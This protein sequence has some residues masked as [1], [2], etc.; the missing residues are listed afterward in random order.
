MLTLGHLGLCGLCRCRRRQPRWWTSCVCG[1]CLCLLA[2]PCP[3]FFCPAPRP[4]AAAASLICFLSRMVALASSR[5]VFSRWCLCWN[6][7]CARSP[8][9]SESCPPRLLICSAAHSRLSRC[10]SDPCCLGVK[11]P[12]RILSPRRKV[13]ST[14]ALVLEYCWLRSA[15]CGQAW[16]WSEVGSGSGWRTGLLRVGD[17]FRFRNYSCTHLYS[18]PPASTPTGYD[19]SLAL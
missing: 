15:I 6:C 2:L 1:C 7:W 13:F 12:Q 10:P 5:T 14:G 4:Q 11:R 17:S 18:A 16:A 19:G 3:S 9:W 8:S